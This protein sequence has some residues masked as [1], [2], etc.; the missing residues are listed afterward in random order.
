MIRS[1][2]AALKM[3]LTQLDS[4]TEDKRILIRSSVNRIN[5]ISND[6][7]NHGKKLSNDNTTAVSNLENAMLA[8]LVDSVV[9]EKR[10]SLRDKANISLEARLDKSY[11][12][13]SLINSVEM[14]RLLS[15]AITNAA[16]AFDFNQGLVEVI[17]ESVGDKVLLIIKDNGKGIPPH[18]LD[19]LGLHGVTHGKEGTQSGSG[20]GV[21]HAKKTIESF[22]GK[23]EIKSKVGHGTSIII[24]LKKENPPDW[25]V[26]KLLI[27]KNQTIVATDDDSSILEIWKQKFSGFIEHNSIQ[28]VTCTSGKCLKEWILNNKESSIDAIYLMDFELLGQKQTGL[29][30][31][32]ELLLNQRAILVSSRYEESQ[33]KD[34]CVKLGVKMIPI[35]MSSLVPIELEQ[36][37]Q[38]LNCLL[39]ESEIVNKPIILETDSPEASPSK[40]KYDLCLI[41]DDRE[42]IH[43]LWGTMAKSRGLKIIMFSTPSEFY[44]ASNTIDKQTPIFVDV[45]LGSPGSGIDF[46]HK[47]NKLGFNEINLATGYPAD[48]IEVPSFIRRV[49]GKDFPI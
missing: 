16:E 34:R 39:F 1:P 44:A 46:S 8:T 47:I 40:I 31:I 21:Y 5:D 17:L 30:L 6:L 7:L 12:L 35:G 23:Y 27:K 37:K 38:K 43:F 20:L 15:N 2:L 45:S 13:F 32:D 41:D 48:S 42:L 29:D 4:I 19:K 36:T 28:L 25:F 26:Q 14:K 49:V 9:S 24:T 18:I 11:G 10:I 3:L 22:G 33:I